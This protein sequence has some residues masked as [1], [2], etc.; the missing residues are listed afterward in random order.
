MAEK[1]D[2]PKGL[3]TL[4]PVQIKIPPQNIYL[5]LANILV[6]VLVFIANSYLPPEVPLFYGLV[7]GE[8]QLA[9]SYLLVLPS[10]VS[11]IIILINSMV[12]M[13]VED[14]FIKSVLIITNFAVTFFSIITTIKIILL[15]GSF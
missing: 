10:L 13:Y 12:S 1:K 6:I 11:L 9:S 7:Y 3:S 14:K 4:K 8:E 5:G 15:V 2:A